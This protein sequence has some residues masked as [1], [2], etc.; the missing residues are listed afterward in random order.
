LREWQETFY[1]ECD[2][3]RRAGRVWEWLS[4]RTEKITV[5]RAR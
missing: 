2:V 4:L 3:H 1:D 5:L